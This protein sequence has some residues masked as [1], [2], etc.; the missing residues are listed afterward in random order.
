M[1]AYVDRDEYDGYKG[2]TCIRSR[3]MWMLTLIEIHKKD[4]LLPRSECMKFGCGPGS[5]L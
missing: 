5:E 3:D 2:R 4:G 1:D